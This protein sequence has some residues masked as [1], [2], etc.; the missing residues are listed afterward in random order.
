[1]RGY[2]ATIAVTALCG[3]NGALVNPPKE[4]AVKIMGVRD[5][6]A[7]MSEVLDQVRNGEVVEVTKNGRAIA[8]II[9]VGQQV[10]P[11][12]RR[13][14]LDSMNALAEELGRHAPSGTNVAQT[15]ADMRQ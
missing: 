14:V 15:I 5:L 1:L 4:A 7:H 3:H 6:K 8:R 11:E 9:P 12:A 2:N 10:G 13:A